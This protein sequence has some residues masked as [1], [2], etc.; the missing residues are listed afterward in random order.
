[1]Q[2]E[3]SCYGVGVADCRGIPLQRDNLVPRLFSMGLNEMELR[4]ANL[5]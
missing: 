5:K 2:E 4:K 1:M 3:T